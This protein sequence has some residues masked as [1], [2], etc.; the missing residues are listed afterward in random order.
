MF[1]LN[2]DAYCL[3]KNPLTTDGSEDGFPTF[4]SK[5]LARRPHSETLPYHLQKIKDY[6][7]E[8][9]RFFPAGEELHHLFVVGIAGIIETTPVDDPQGRH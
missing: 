1:S 5:H 8:S 9:D 7:R 2:I 4:Q 6:P 3:S